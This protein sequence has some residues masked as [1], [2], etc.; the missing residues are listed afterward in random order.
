MLGVLAL[1]ALAGEPE[2]GEPRPGEPEPGEAHAPAPVDGEAPPAPAP[3]A[4]PP[5][6]TGVNPERTYHR[7]LEAWAEGDQARALW[8]ARAANAHAA[9]AHAASADGTHPS[10]TE[11]HEPARLLEA[12][13]LW[14]LRERAEAK[15]TLQRL[16]RDHDQ[17]GPADDAV[18]AA[19]RRFLA[20]KLGPTRRDTLSLSV[21]GD[22]FVR[23]SGRAVAAGP[24]LAASVDVP[25]ASLLA[26]RADFALG[27][28]STPSAL[29]DGPLLGLA[30]AARVPLGPGALH[31]VGTV[32]PS[33]WLL[34]GPLVE[35]GGLRVEPGVRASLG[36]DARTG[37]GLGFAVEGGGWTFPGM[38][39]E[40]PGYMLAW[41]L[42]A[43]LVYWF[44]AGQRRDS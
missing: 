34:A 29:L 14:S 20:R 6:A 39:P 10:T 25:V 44:P 30:V 23:G 26:V 4:P 3:A 16:A 8:L 24:G 15:S 31:A 19:A 40:L 11:E 21:A 17:G 9:N 7:A 12:Y 35:S 5:H 36:V 38:V 1:S 37:A 18:R 32:G 27:A 42:R 22:V 2:P 41:D 28:T 43:G 33:L 13:A